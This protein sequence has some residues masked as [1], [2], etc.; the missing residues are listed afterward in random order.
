[1][2]ELLKLLALLVTCKSYYCC[3]ESKDRDRSRA[4]TLKLPFS[5]FTTGRKVEQQTFV[6]ACEA[7]YLLRCFSES[8]V[9]TRRHVREIV[10][11]ISLGRS[12]RSATWAAIVDDMPWAEQAPN[13]AFR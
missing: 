3:R 11:E 9:L 8:Q 10:T 7:Y 4:V 12:P 1:M 2:V 13:V 5:T 6:D